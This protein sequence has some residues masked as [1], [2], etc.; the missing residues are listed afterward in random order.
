M[1]TSEGYQQCYNGQLAVDEDFQV[2]VAN[3]LTANASDQGVMLGLMDQVEQTLETQPDCVLADAG[4]RKEDDFEA[5]EQRG[6]EA[7][8]SVRREGKDIGDIDANAYP[9]THRMVEK[10]STPDG[11]ERYRDRK[12]IV[13][14]V[15]GWIKQ[16]M[17]FRRFSIRGLDG[18]AGERAEALEVS[19]LQVTAP[20]PEQLRASTASTAS[21]RR[22]R[23]NAVDTTSKD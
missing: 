12:H 2:I 3:E 13:E 8:V 7:Y 1:K 9:A 14:A 15:N 20:S 17:G 16:V 10:L 5:L 18:A 19:R 11:R 23:L 6:I 21:I 22:R 4:Y